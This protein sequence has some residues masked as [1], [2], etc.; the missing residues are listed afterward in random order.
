MIH[1]RTFLCGLTLGGLAAPRATEAQRAGTIYRVGVLTNVPPSAPEVSR[2]WEAF[3]Q[4]L[5]ERGW[6]EG[7]AIDIEYRFVEG[8][9][10]RFPALAAELVS[11][12]PDLIVALAN[13]GARAAKQA[14]STIPIVKIYIFD[15]V[16]D[17]LVASLG[18][19]GAN[20]TGLTAIV[21]QGV[22]GKHLELL[23]EVVPKVSRVAILFN[24]GNPVSTAYWE[25]AQASA[26]VLDVKLQPLEVRNH[27]E[28]E[29]TFTAMTKEHAG[30]LLVLPYPL[31]YAH[32]RRI[33]DLAA[34]N[35][36]PA[37][38]PF[39]E[40][41]EAGGLMAYGANP[42]DMFRRAAYFVD[43]I[44]KGAKPADL[45]V[46]QPTKFEL[47]INAKTAKTLGLTIPP[48]LLARADQVI[49]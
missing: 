3:R 38:Y 28:L 49:E 5:R 12:K 45:P 7:Q 25:E 33:A 30:A 10:D 27:H 19:P 22:V 9:V 41:V 16:G 21:S 15:P 32:A 6:I 40:F 46:E 29:G 26:R 24:S 43:K 4:G 48:S 18:R 34:T 39:R 37:V 47:V 42:T 11:L 35:R 14:T 36:L 8:K 2:N 20:V 23:R 44:L 31:I 13:A 17:G 1:R